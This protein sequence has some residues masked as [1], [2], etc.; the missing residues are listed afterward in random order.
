MNINLKTDNSFS[1]GISRLCE[2]LNFEISDNGIPL[3]A[4]KRET[5]GATL[6]NGVGTIYYNATHHFFRELG[7]FLENAKKEDEFEISED[8][9]FT[10]ISAMLDVSRGAA[11]TVKAIKEQIDYLAI[12]GYNMVMLYSEDMIELPS[13]PYFGYLQGR[14]TEAELRELDD[15]AFSYGIELIPCL[16][17]YGHM[18]KYLKW[19]EASAIKDTPSVMLARE[20]KTF[21]FLDELIGHTSKVFRSRRINIGMD[22][23]WDM[24]K[25]KFLHKHGYVKPID[26]FN[27]FMPRLIEITNKY[28]LT[29]M[30]WSD[31]YFRANEKSGE[32]YYEEETI[33]PEETKKTIPEEVELVFWHYGEKPYCDDYMLQKHNELN[34]KVI[35]AGG[36]WSWNG[37]FP[38][39]DYAFETTKFSLEACRKNNVRE[40]M[41]T[42]WLNDNG[43]C[44]LF[45]NLYGLSFTA[46]LCYNENA[47]KETLYSRFGA[48]T[49][50]CG[51]AFDDMCQY[52]NIFDGNETYENFHDRFLGKPL[53]WQEIMLGQYDTHL[54]GRPMSGHYK[55]YAQKMRAVPNDRWSYLYDFAADVFEYLAT[56]TEIAENLVT[57]YKNDDKETLKYISTTLLPTLYEQTKKMHQSNH[58]M[59]FRNL[60]AFG[61]NVLDSRYG[62]MESRCL[63]AKERINDYLE[64]KIDI[65]EELEATRL[66]K[67]L[68]GFNGYGA[69]AFA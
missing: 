47:D 39:Y 14:Y 50:G 45:A 13:R 40:A 15:Y 58:D 29:P 2:V 7:I 23:A 66:Y 56:K 69:I 19:G 10:T 41:M 30:M 35:F 12:M 55:K 4:E 33:I 11:P 51:E 34:R 18:A 60:K 62:G 65:I 20:E 21:E 68:T 28:G 54:E 22:E 59:W 48:C 67:P 32:L 44:D 24:G 17:C 31:M 64:G 38:E 43:E 3:Y 36:L 26:I 1:E 8:G 46:E 25:G 16:E 61:W 6:K 63:S 53:F 52:H 5:P 27:E 49:G 57:A 42:I 9:F 37:H